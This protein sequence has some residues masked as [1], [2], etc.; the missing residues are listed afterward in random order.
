MVNI[1]GY[2]LPHHPPY[3]ASARHLDPRLAFSLS[4]PKTLHVNVDYD[5]VCFL[6]ISK[7]QAA[8]PDFERLTA[9]CKRHASRS[10]CSPA[11][12]FAIEDMLPHLAL[13]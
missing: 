8:P 4:P 2:D 5:F 11:G 1:E 3:R 6:R 13:G 7:A 12:A 10:T 9:G